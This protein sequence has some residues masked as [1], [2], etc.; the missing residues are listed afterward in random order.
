M[1]SFEIKLGRPSIFKCLKYSGETVILAIS[2][3]QVIK[4]NR[5]FDLGIELFQ[6]FLAWLIIESTV[7]MLNTYHIY[8]WFKNINR[9]FE[10][11]EQLSQWYNKTF[12]RRLELL[13]YCVSLII[14][15]SFMQFFYNPPKEFSYSQIQIYIM[16]YIVSIWTY[17][18]LF[19]VIGLFLGIIIRGVRRPTVNN[20]NRL[21]HALSICF[22][23]T[24]SK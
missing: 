4:Y 20:N 17:A 23:Q 14:R 5:S 3:A 8:A 6:Q 2:L 11:Y 1:S 12:Y 7:F 9:L 18:Q 22:S 24:T 19:S 15:F 21:V 16:I 13:M 10:N